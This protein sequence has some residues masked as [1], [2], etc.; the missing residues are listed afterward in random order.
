M[1]NIYIFIFL[2]SFINTK[3]QEYTAQN[4]HSHNDYEQSSPFELA[5]NERFGSIEADI[6]LSN[7]IILVGHDSKDL[8]N[9]RTLE[10]LYLNPINEH[11]N[12]NRKLQLL[13]DIKTEPIST[14]NTLIK[15]LE[16]YPAIINDTNIKIVLTGNLPNDSDFIN[17]PKYIWFDG[18]VNKTYT[19]IEL[20]K[21]ALISEDFF[22]II[23]WNK[24]WMTDSISIRKIHFAI[25]QTHSIG[26]PIRF[27]ATPDNESTWEFLIKMKVDF[28]NTDKITLLS[29]FLNN[30]NRNQKTLPYNRI[31]KSAGTVL[32]YGKPTL[33]NHA[34]DVSNL[35]DKNLVV[36]QERYGF[37]IVNIEENKII[38][39]FSFSD[40][41]Q[42][43]NFMTVYSGLTTY[44]ANGK[45]YILFSAANSK[46]SA[47]MI[48]EWNHGISN[49]VD[50]PIYAVAPAINALPNQIVINKEKN[51]VYIY[52]VLN[53]NNELLKIDFKTKNIVWR[54]STGVAPYGLVIESNKIWVTNWAGMT[55]TDSTKSTAGVPWGLAYTDSLT[56]ATKNGTVSIFDF[57]GK[58]L[59]EINVG[60][61][62]NAIISS[63]DHLK[64]YVANGSSDDIS[65]IDAI[66]E[67]VSSSINVNILGKILQGSTPNALFI[68]NDNTRLY[69]SNGIDN[70]ILVYDLKIKKRLGLIP[71]E[72]YPAGLMIK[73][74]KLIVANLE[75][76][77]ANVI[78][79]V[80]KAREIHNQLASISIIP[81][82][83]IKILE[84]HTRNVIAQ[85][86][87]NRTEQWNLKPRENRK[88][89]PIPERVGEPSIFK[90]V[91]YIIKENKTYDQVFGDM[92]SGNGDSSL[93]VFGDRITPNQHA[94]A[95]QF[96]LMDNYYASGKSSAEGHQWT[97]AGMVS[98][99]VEKNVRAWFRSYPHRQEDA[100][101]YN[102]A[103]FIWNHALSYGKSVRV[104]GEACE[105]KYNK[106]LKW[107]DL[108]LQ[109]QQNKQPNW[110]NTTTIDNLLPYIHPFYPDCDNITFSDQQRASIF[111]ED[112]RKLEKIDSLPNL[113]VLSLPNDH[114][115]GTSPNYPTPNA[116]VADNDLALGR[117]VEMISK[118]K[119]W[120]S[121]VIFVTE[122]DSQGGWDHISAYRTI[123]FA[124]SPYSNNKVNSTQY[125]Q[126]SMLR[127]IEQ[128]LGLPPMN[129]VD[130]T[131]RLM[132][133][134]FITKPNAAIFNKLETNIPL[135]QMNPS[136]K[137]LKGTAKLMA[138]ASQ[139]EV[140]NEVDGGK[141]DLMNR[142]IWFYSKGNKPYPKF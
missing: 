47:I 38:D 76:E 43:S 119:S 68:S 3:G 116:M 49:I 122:D 133:D 37:F 86:L 36:I 21:I 1:K 57:N 74:N 7:G 35:A 34:M 73:N 66:K 84:E 44:V 67:K 12:P 96:G 109:Y 8:K 65:I 141:D 28:I 23:S 53:G 39:H 130:A 126:V 61:H 136:I 26:K 63:P 27:W 62:P 41:P 129:L 92:P 140:F 99:Y 91:V 14:I 85:N 117:I 11:N 134:C 31:I 127:T 82:P 104:Y 78:D 72:A 59:N 98:D 88:P 125:N 112:W 56:G 138:L 87:L 123:G 81:L 64:V 139:N 94:L 131:S 97:D 124:I 30:R 33:E 70:A 55:V 58:H 95:K 83:N 42:Y 32:R 120:D 24:N 13:I 5:Y 69:V 16:K 102:K 17:Y 80:K 71:T 135:D 128:I 106:N 101:V 137:V 105:T 52:T 20:S 103:G 4:A 22:K 113:M 9:D 111:I 19:S 100:L 118:S 60:L 75:S 48:V 40:Y 93:C 77:G 15:I 132:N 54:S 114:T 89:L 45:E 25:N 107:Q 121:T 115:S 46:N 90:H 142:I 50:I 18:R 108:Y 29:D 2:L 110:I 6:H 51:N 79:V 10:N